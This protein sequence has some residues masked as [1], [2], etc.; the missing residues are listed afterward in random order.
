VHDPQGPEAADRLAKRL[1]TA[2]DMRLRSH[3]LSIGVNEI[4][5]LAARLVPPHLLDHH[6]VDELA[7][8]LVDA[9]LADLAEE[10][11]GTN[12]WSHDARIPVPLHTV[13]ATVL[14]LSL[15]VDLAQENNAQ[16]WARSAEIASD[17]LITQLTSCR[18]ADERAPKL[19]LYC[20]QPGLANIARLFEGMDQRISAGRW[21]WSS[22]VGGNGIVVETL[23]A[24]LQ[25]AAT[26]LRSLNARYGR[27]PAPLPGS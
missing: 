23:R 8:A 17:N 4:A 2:V 16:E 25:S 12:P 26:A 1:C 5:P 11:P 7:D 13:A 20:P 3:G 15:C 21:A 6:S 14:T 9:V 22:T 18:A 24:Q 27:S 19:V 10:R